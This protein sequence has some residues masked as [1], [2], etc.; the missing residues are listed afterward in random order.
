[1]KQHNLCLVVIL[2]ILSVVL[3]FVLY[4]KGVQTKSANKID[5]ETRISQQGDTYSVKKIT[6][7]AGNEFDITLDNGKRIYAKLAVTTVPDAKHRVITYLNETINPK[8][9]IL[10]KQGETW[11]VDL[12]V[13]MESQ[14]SLLDEEVSL[15]NWLKE[16]G[17][18]WQDL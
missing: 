18:I 10:G 8:V 1:M 7:L 6:V 13:R 2:I 16:N 9:V 17:L 12:Y 15:S 11:I 5:I 3:S 14:A 4:N